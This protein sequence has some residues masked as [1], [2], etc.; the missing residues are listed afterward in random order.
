MK[1]KE[2]VSKRKHFEERNRVLYGGRGGVEGGSGFVLGQERRE[3]IQE[4]V[5][6]Q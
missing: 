6:S 1:F 2:T 5:Q 4:E 3:C